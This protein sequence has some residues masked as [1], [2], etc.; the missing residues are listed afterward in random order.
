LAAAVQAVFGVL[1][2]VI[3]FIMAHRILAPIVNQGWVFAAGM[4]MA[5]DPA[6]A[7]I[8]ASL[9]TEPLFNLLITAF[10][11]FTVLYV[12]TER[13]WHTALAALSL[14]LAM[15]ARPSAIY[16]WIVVPLIIIPLARRKWRFVLP[17]AV[18]GLLVYLAWSYRNWYYT[19]VFT[20]SLQANFSLLFLR[21]ISAEHLATGAS[22]ADLYIAYVR[23][24]YTR[25]G[26]LGALGT[27]TDL[28]FWDFHVAS[29]P[30][31]YAQMGSLAIEKLLKYWPI[32]VMST[33][34]GLWR[35]YALTTDLPGWFTP[36]E[37]VYH[38]VIYSTALYGAIQGIRSRRWALVL[39]QGVPILYFTSLTLVA[40]I[41]AMTSRMRT[42]ITAPIIILATYGMHQLWQ[43]T[44]E[45]HILQPRLKG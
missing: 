1:T 37:L 41:S 21:A 30:E 16:L 13:W 38:A 20:Y 2:I 34:L 19:G 22:V 28:S 44:K 3:G 45:V 24:L 27:V 9:M 31:L 39:T 32:A 7:S 36:V 33:P 17:V 14:A 11:L 18:V 29:T 10:I 6:A 23:E 4:M 43:K 12:Q 35:M 40:Q 26:N 15:L 25:V 5:L 8:S 42:P